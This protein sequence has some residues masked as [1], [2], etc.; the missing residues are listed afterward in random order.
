ME[1]TKNKFPSYG[2]AGLILVI[3][4]WILNWSLSG[5]RTHWGFF[6]LWLGFCLTVDAI[7]F[8]RKGNSLISRNLKK[9]LLL[10]VFSIPV[11]WLF[12]FLNLFTANWYYDGKEYFSDFEFFLLSSLSFST[13]MPAVFSAAELASTFKWIKKININLRIP[14][15][16]NVVKTFLASGLLM[17]LLLITLPEY[18]YPFI[19][20]SVY[21]II[22]PLNY[23]FGR[24]NLFQSTDK[25]NWQPVLFLWTGVLICAFFWEMWNYFSY[26]KWVYHLPGLNI[27]HIFEMPLPGYLGYLPFSLELYAIYNLFI[28]RNSLSPAENELFGNG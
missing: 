18:F 15:E 21:F 2:W 22:E 12:E 11:W 7:V 4:F 24:R 17:L 19:W 25:R 3:I 1:L 20:V 5:L 16:E 10:F 26:P 6:P 27:L 28:K 23:F 13:V 9:Y 8:Y 14:A